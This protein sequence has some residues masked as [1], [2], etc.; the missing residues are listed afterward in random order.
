MRLSATYQ[1]KSPVFIPPSGRF[2]AVLAVFWLSLAAP[3]TGGRLASL[4]ELHGLLRIEHFTVR[5]R[6]RFHPRPPDEQRVAAAGAGNR[7]ARFWGRNKHFF[8]PLHQLD[9]L[10]V[11]VQKAIIPSPPEAFGQDVLQ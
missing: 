7:G 4:A 6:P 10:A 1:V 2:S 8:N 3:A 9:P 11:G 5:D